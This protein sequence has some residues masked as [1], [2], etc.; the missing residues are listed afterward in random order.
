ME[1]QFFIE[2]Y[3]TKKSKWLNSDLWDFKGLLG[4]QV[5]EY[6]QNPNNPLK[7]H[8]SEFKK[9]EAVLLFLIQ[10]NH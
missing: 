1:I 2:T 5:I 4:F 3:N 6:P 7:S 9:N 8:K 10:S